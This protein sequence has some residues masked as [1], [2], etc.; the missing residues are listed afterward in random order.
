MVSHP[1]RSISRKEL[2]LHISVW[3]ILFSYAFLY[4]TRANDGRLLINWSRV[5]LHTVTVCLS[6]FLFYVNYLWLIPKLYYQNAKWEF[7]LINVALVV[8][9][10]I[11]VYVLHPRIA[12]C[13]ASMQHNRPRHFAHRPIAWVLHLRETILLFF[14][15]PMSVIVR[16]AKRWRELQEAVREAQQRQT[17]VELVYLRSQFNPH[18]LLNTLNNIYSLIRIS[19]MKAQEAVIDLSNMLRYVLYDSQDR[20]VSIVREAEFMQHYIQLM[21]IRLSSD[22]RVTV[23]IDVSPDSTTL[24][25]P[26]LFISLIENAFKH[27]VSSVQPSFIDIR[28]TDVD[29]RVTCSI[30]NS[31]FPKPNS[32]R[33]GSGI[34][35]EQVARRLELLYNG[36]YTW[37]HGSR[38]TD[39]GEIYESTIVIDTTCGEA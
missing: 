12:S 21:R 6:M 22:V 16:N 18:F 35:L 32:D 14:I 13:C 3:L 39:N 5:Q 30:C 19:P 11:A 4:I 37:V 2:L 8:L 33:S 10:V 27:G 24:I 15:V 23:D 29:G 9:L 20:Y 36:Q 1:G 25:A 17:E 31:S 7:V 34:G 28:M 26:L 38:Q